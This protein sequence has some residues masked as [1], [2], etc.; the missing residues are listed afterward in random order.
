MGFPLE[1]VSATWDSVFEVTVG[2]FN[3]ES[4]SYRSQIFD[5][6]RAIC[7][8]VIQ[9]SCKATIIVDGSFVTDKKFPDDVDIWIF[10][11]P[12]GNPQE[13]RFFYYDALKQFE[14]T[15][16]LSRL[17]HV[18]IYPVLNGRL[19]DTLGDTPEEFLSMDWYI[20]KLGVW[21]KSGRPDD[22]PKGA[23]LLEL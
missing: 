5:E 9:A 6:A 4:A 23:F 19:I 8:L 11:A 20:E 22:P 15:A 7:D 18:M 16:K 17:V 21:F 13:N 2:S 1:I 12:L 14:K 3:G 10:A